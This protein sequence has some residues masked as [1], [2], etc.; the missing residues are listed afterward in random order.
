MLINLEIE[1]LMLYD[2]HSAV[3]QERK[4]YG[5]ADEVDTLPYR[6]FEEYDLNYK[7]F[8]E[9]KFILWKLLAIIKYS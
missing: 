8:S 9:A 7:L 4:R 2:M 5:M 1:D 6:P 3:T